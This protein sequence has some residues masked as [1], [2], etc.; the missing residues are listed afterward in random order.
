MES[1]FATFKPIELTPNPDKEDIVKYY[2]DNDITPENPAISNF[3]QFEEAKSESIPEPPDE[4]KESINFIGLN[5]PTIPKKS[6]NTTKIP[7]NEFGKYV[8]NYF[9]S[10]GLSKE[11]AAGIAGN[12]Q[13]ESNFNPSVYGDNKTSY[14]L[15]QWHNNRFNNLIQFAKNNGA[16]YSDPKI[17]LDFIWEELQTY[18]NKALKEL[19]KTSTAKDAAKSF[20]THFER[21]KLYSPIREYYANSL[22]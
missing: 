16:D 1:N 7:I 19:L 20:A 11:Q 21:M 5:I 15:A 14:G 4:T 6:S 3:L 13:A 8:V 2:L 12:L 10:K 9:V 22:I 18:E 17:Q